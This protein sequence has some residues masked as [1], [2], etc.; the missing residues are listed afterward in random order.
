M[1]ATVNLCYL[2]N[3]QYTFR[4]IKLHGWVIFNFMGQCFSSLSCSN[5]TFFIFALLVY[6]LYGVMNLIFFFKSTH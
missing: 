2:G 4:T 5:A 3:L 1:M 6:H